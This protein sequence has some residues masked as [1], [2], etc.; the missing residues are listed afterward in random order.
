LQRKKITIVFICHF[1]VSKK[2]LKDFSE[3]MIY[4]FNKF[5]VHKFNIQKQMAF[6]Y[7]VR[8]PYSQIYYTWFWPRV[9]KNYKWKTKESSKTKTLNPH[10]HIT[11]L[12]WW[13]DILSQSHVIVSSVM[14]SVECFPALN[15]KICFL[16][17]KQ[18]PK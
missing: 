15:L 1:L 16:K 17:S 10:K 7:T 5:A 18:Y 14:W 11:Q 3:K 6:L 8:P 2:F 4:I 13:G 12:N 9:I